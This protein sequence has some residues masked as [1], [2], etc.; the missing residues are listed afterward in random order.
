[1]ALALAVARGKA[2]VRAPEDSIWGPMLWPTQKAP[3]SF[4]ERPPAS[5]EAAIA[6]VRGHLC[7]HPRP[8]PAGVADDTFC[9]NMYVHA[10]VSHISCLSV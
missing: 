2:G 3:Q 7:A 4:A 10:P 6:L 5:K 8:R 9:L 1:M